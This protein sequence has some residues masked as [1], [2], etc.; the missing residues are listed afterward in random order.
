MT[1]LRL[2]TNQ[3][4]K[5]M[6]NIN[7]QKI[8]DSNRFYL[9]LTQAKDVFTGTVLA[10]SYNQQLGKFA[11]RDI[12]GVTYFII[13]T[14]T[15]PNIFELTRKV[16]EFINNFEKIER[17]ANK[18]DHSNIKAQVN[19]LTNDE[20]YKIVADTLQYNIKFSNKAIER[21][22]KIAYYSGYELKIVKRQEVELNE[23]FENYIR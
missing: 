16:Q 10:K 9:Y 2:S 3:N 19:R 5:Q 13:E 23:S 20:R 1:A 12:N 14:F 11:S 22:A 8:N 7:L 15:N 4:K 17:E 6:N 18:Y 21:L